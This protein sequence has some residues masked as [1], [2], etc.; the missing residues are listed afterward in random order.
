MYRKKFVASTPEQL[1]P[2]LGPDWHVVCLYESNQKQADFFQGTIEADTVSEEGRASKIRIW[3]NPFTHDFELKYLA[4]F[5]TPKREL[6]WPKA[7]GSC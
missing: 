3:F 5:L 1:V 6:V 4:R 2:A 7:T